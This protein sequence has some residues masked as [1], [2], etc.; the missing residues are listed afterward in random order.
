MRSIDRRL[1]KLLITA[2]VGKEEVTVLAARKGPQGI[3]VVGKGA[4]PSLGIEGGEPVHPG[5]AAEQLLEA[6]EKALPEAE[7]RFGTLYLNFDDHRMESVC[8]RAFLSLKGEGEVR[9]SDV[10]EVCRLAE[11][12][13]GNFEK[14]ALYA[15]P[16]RFLLDDRDVVANP[17]GIF[18]QKL[19]VWMHVLLVSSK[20]FEAWQR[21]SERAGFSNAH[22]VPSAWSTACGIFPKEERFRKRMVV[23]LG[24]DLLNLF[25]LAGGGIAE[26]RVLINDGMTVTR[27]VEAV[28]D[29][30]KELFQRHSDAEEI[31]VTGDLLPNEALV[32]G[33]REQ[34]PLSVREVSPVRVPELQ[35]PSFSALAGLLQVAGEL[36]KESFWRPFDG[37]GGIWNRVKQKA[38]AFIGEYF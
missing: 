32:Q 20:R 30:G 27:A 25:V 19:E 23:D 9:E 13:V 38:A 5:D 36:D 26:S 31:C 8:S 15:H 12:L 22:L 33:L 34:F 6:F 4:A 7:R 21:V 28:S 37:E 17:V 24:S 2:D 18:G 3:Q 1:S 11:R 35:G 14:R 10:R 16:L 29:A